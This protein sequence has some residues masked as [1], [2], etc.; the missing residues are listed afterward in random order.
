MVMTVSNST[1]LGDLRFDVPL[2]TVTEASK[3]LVVPRSTLETWA[4]GYE[5]RPK[6]RRLVR[7]GDLERVDTRG[8]R[9]LESQRPMCSTHF[10]VP[11]YR[12]NGYDPPSTGLC[13]TSAP[14][15]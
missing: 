2:Y 10:D 6:A 12:C 5:R 14:T 11:A 15:L 9:S 4:D 8:C 3:Y 13:G 1:L 7:E